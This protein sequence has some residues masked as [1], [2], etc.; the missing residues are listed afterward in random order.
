MV[1]HSTCCCAMF[2][3]STSNC[4]IIFVAFYWRGSICSCLSYFCACIVFNSVYNLFISYVPFKCSVFF[5]ILCLFLRFYILTLILSSCCS[6]C[7]TCSSSSSIVQSCVVLSN[8]YATVF[9]CFSNFSYW[10]ATYSFLCSLTYGGVF[11]FILSLS[12]SI[13]F[14]YWSIV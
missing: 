8:N 5:I 3:F 10:S 14:L 9:N 2:F 11:E 7:Y 1:V 6:H 12:S 13:Y 4:R